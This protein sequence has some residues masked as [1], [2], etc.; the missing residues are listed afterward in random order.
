MLGARVFVSGP[1][2]EAQRWAWRFSV[3]KYFAK[4]QGARLGTVGEDKPVRPAEAAK[5]DSFVLGLSDVLSATSRS[6]ASCSSASPASSS[7]SAGFSPSSPAAA[8]QAEK[9][10]PP[11][12]TSVATGTALFKPVTV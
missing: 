9:S 3:E 6:S 1:F 5:D 2:G 7:V 4:H 10:P 12:L 11:P 8:T